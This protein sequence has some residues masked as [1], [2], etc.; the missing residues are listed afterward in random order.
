VA[1]EFELSQI[2]RARLVPDFE[3]KQELKR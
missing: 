3:R 1:H 2:D